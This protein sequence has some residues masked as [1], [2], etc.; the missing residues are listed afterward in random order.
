MPNTKS[1][2]RK[3]LKAARNLLSI[4]ER[5][6]NSENIASRLFALPAWSIAQTVHCYC[7]FGAEVSTEDVVS[8]AFQDGKRVIVPITA[9]GASILHHR[10]VFPE[11]LF[12]PDAFGIPTPPHSE[13]DFVEPAQILSSHDIILVPLLGFDD[14]CY[15]IGYGKGH[16]D[17]FLA[18][19][20]GVPAFGLAFE[21]QR[22]TRII[23]EPHDIP[24]WGVCT[25]AQ[26]YRRSMET[27]DLK[28]PH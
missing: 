21:C 3:Q 18:S 2:Q 1:E 20:A 7:S 14:R 8:R 10:E 16:Y 4:E 9:E 28:M 25:E 17:R 15:R 6:I 12:V 24:L 11:T 27:H 19:V 22:V 26:F 13:Q 5:R 23:T